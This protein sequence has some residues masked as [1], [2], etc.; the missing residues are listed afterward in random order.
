MDWA[1]G[2]LLCKRASQ[3]A[4]KMDATPTPQDHDLPLKL[5]AQGQGGDVPKRAWV[6]RPGSLASDLAA[7]TCLR[8]L[9]RRDDRR[10][11]TRIRQCA[12]ADASL[13]L[14]FQPVVWWG[15]QQ[16]HPLPPASWTAPALECTCG[17]RVTPSA[18]VS[19][20]QPVAACIC[21][22]VAAMVVVW[23]VNYASK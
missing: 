5:P 18:S 10:R 13:A 19:I 23:M 1:A 20:Y 17:V 2:C 6:R 4:S 3:Q 21:A 9:A 15:Q 12:R 14:R 22:R 7:W 16:F 8:C 11:N